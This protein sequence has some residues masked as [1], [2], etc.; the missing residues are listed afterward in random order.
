MQFLHFNLKIILIEFDNIVLN[1]LFIRK[2]IIEFT[3]QTS[4][5]LLNF[6]Q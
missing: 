2:N 5:F 3:C 6:S 1:I 4:D